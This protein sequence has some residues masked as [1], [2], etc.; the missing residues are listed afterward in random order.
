ME[1]DEVE[2]VA[3]CFKIFPSHKYANIMSILISV[4]IKVFLKLF[5]EIVISVF[6]SLKECYSLLATENE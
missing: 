5:I 6:P 4:Q 3:Y 2:S 1:I